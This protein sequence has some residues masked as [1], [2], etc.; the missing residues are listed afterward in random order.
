MDENSLANINT[1]D[2][3]SALDNPEFL[4]ALYAADTGMSAD[5]MPKLFEADTFLMGME[6]AGANFRPLISL[7]YQQLEEGERLT[8]LREPNNEYDERAI[9]VLTQEG[10]KL[11]YIPRVN[12]LILSRLMDAGYVLYALVRSKELQVREK[13]DYRI[14][15]KVY[16]TAGIKNPAPFPPAEADGSTLDDISELRDMDRL[17]LL[18]TGINANREK[19]YRLSSE[20]LK[21]YLESSTPDDLAEQAGN[22]YNGVEGQKNYKEAA[23]WAKKA[24]DAGSIKAYALLFGTHYFG[25]YGMDTDQQLALQYVRLGAEKGEVQ[26]QYNLGVL[27]LDGSLVEQDSDTA[28]SW[29]EKAAAQGDFSGNIALFMLYYDSKYGMQDEEEALK[30]AIA[31]YHTFNYF[32]KDNKKDFSAILEYIGMRLY[33]D[34]SLDI[35]EGTAFS[36]F[37]KAAENGMACS[38]FYLGLMLLTGDECEKDEEKAKEYIDLAAENGYQAAAE[39]KENGYQFPEDVEKF[40]EERTAAVLKKEVA[41]AKKQLDDSLKNLTD[42]MRQAYHK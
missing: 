32:K 21:R 36:F 1:G 14:V 37:K 41:E 33:E 10:K 19:K 6:I 25:G 27:Y 23:Y 17:A 3:A 35:S 24:V 7:L 11:G 40:V 22:F 16:L 26:C 12:N 18:A 28:R 34:V 20:A 31:A 39:M 42:T 2:L 29:F 8:L 9:A 4:A 38:Q 5:G 15:I 30:Y 13:P